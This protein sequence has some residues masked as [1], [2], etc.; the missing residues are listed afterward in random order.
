MVQVYLSLR[1]IQVCVFP[2]QSPSQIL[3]EVG[4]GRMW[5]L[6]PFPSLLFYIMNPA[7]SPR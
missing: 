3:G 4:E 1:E 6:F 2:Y 7:L 5:N